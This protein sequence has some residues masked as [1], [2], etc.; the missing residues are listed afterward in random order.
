[1]NT[2]KFTIVPFE[3][4]F[5][6][7]AKGFTD[8]QIGQDYYSVSEMTEN[9]EKSKTSTNEITSFLLLDSSEKIQGIRLAY[10][11]GNWA[12]GKGKKLRPELWPFPIESAGYFQSL[13]I[14]EVA[15]GQGFGPKLSEMSL[16]IFRKLDHKGVIT[17]CWKESPGNTSLK[18]LVEFGFTPIVE[19]PDYWIDVDYV[20]TRDGK[21]C[22]C[23]AIEM[24]YTL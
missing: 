9:Q 8:T 4:K 18:Y 11:A 21:P 19:H 17:H 20:C 3:K 2:F 23:T 14:S 22:R 13:F 12:H 16:Q 5:I 7:E 6:F 1:M 10:P 24:S 15:R